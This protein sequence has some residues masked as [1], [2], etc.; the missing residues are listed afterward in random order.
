MK[1]VNEREEKPYNQCIDCTYIGK[2]CDGPNFL[3]MSID[4][5]CEW[6]HIRKEY[7]NWTNAKIA[8]LSGISKISVDRVM[9]GNVK[10]LRITTMQAITKALVNGSWGKYPC[11]GVTAQVKD[12]NPRECKHLQSAV[13]D[14]KKK[15]MHLNEEIE[16]L[17][18]QI[19]VKDIQ[20]ANCS[21]LIETRG[22]FM[23]RK[24]ANIAFLSV[25]LFI[26]IFV[27]IGALL[28][29]KFNPEIGFF[30]HK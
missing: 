10:D 5:W 9:S 8:E 7:L 1:K 2:S 29:D 4:R 6:C 19:D 25:L 16:T 12:C 28:V 3:A 20:I 23:K 18:H 26:F 24:D 21:K 30:W 11:A 17:K 13:D 15:A 22:Q 27:I 14:E